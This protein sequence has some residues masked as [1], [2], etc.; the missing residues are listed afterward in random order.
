MCG[1]FITAIVFQEAEKSSPS[2]DDIFKSGKKYNGRA[3]D[4]EHE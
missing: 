3:K 2:M 4:G 1:I